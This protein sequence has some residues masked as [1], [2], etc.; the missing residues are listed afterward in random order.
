MK[1][2]TIL[3]LCVFLFGALSMGFSSAD[4]SLTPTS[5]SSTI[6]IGE[7]VE[8][9]IVIENTGDKDIDLDLD[10]FTVTTGTYSVDMKVDETAIRNLEVG[11]EFDISVT[12]DSTFDEIGTYSGSLVVEDANTSSTL[13]RYVYYTIEV[14]PDPKS[15]KEPTVTLPDITR[16]GEEASITVKV[17]NNGTEALSDVSVKVEIPQVQAS[18]TYTISS[19][20]VGSSDTSIAELQIPSSS[21]YQEA[22]VVVTVDYGGLETVSSTTPFVLLPENSVYFQ[23][24]QGESSVTLEASLDENTD[25]DGLRLINGYDSDISKIVFK[26][27]SDIDDFEVEDHIEFQETGEDT[28]DVDDDDKDDDYELGPGSSYS[29]DIDFKNLD[30]IPIQVHS[31]TDALSVEYD[32][33]IGG[34]TYSI[35]EYF[36]VNIEADKDEVDINFG[37]S[38]LTFTIERGDDEDFELELD[39]NEEFDVENVTFE[40]GEDFELKTD[41]SE[42]LSSSQFEFEEVGEFTIDEGSSDFKI[43]FTS[44]DSDQVGTYE[45]TFI[46]SYNGEQ[47]DEIP[48]TIRISDGV[49]IKSIKQLSDAM[50]GETLRVNVLIDNEEGTQEIEVTGVISNVNDFG[51]DLDDI[52]TL[53]ISK[54]SEETVQLTFQI[55]D[56]VKP[57][58]LLLEVTIEYEDPEDE[59]ER[60][61][62][63]EE[64]EIEVDRLDHA[65]EVVTSFVSPN[66]VACNENMQAKVTYRNIGSNDENIAVSARVLETNLRSKSDTSELFENA[67]D[68]YTYVF[69]SEGLEVGGYDVQFKI[70]Y[71]NGELTES[72]ISSFQVVSCIE[73]EEVITSEIKPTLPGTPVDEQGNIVIAASTAEAGVSNADSAVSR[74]IFGMSVRTVTLIL[75]GLVV[76]VGVAFG[77]LYFL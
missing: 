33:L 55:P 54:D 23:G 69:S 45:G 6:I 68:S 31:A 58:D 71:N 21:A 18:Q 11:E 37:Q 64:K 62:F 8:S 34:T 19:L 30:E 25:D 41:S 48:V 76:L 36:D 32:V 12:P 46:L 24:F 39:N 38:S 40:I 22:D 16:V 17:E 35:I 5:F 20:S 49:F 10:D 50:P 56:D 13:T 70:S 28:L 2:N 9:E 7:S 1:L 72:A 4:F 44:D 43:E 29:F 53:V 26:L 52:E 67:Q 3:I 63:V 74:E 51:T 57:N 14:I 73:E 60:V 66:I 59:D 61:Q 77:L 47:V 27:E 15:V 65:I 75:S 42:D